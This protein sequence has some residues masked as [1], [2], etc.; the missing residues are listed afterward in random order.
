MGEVRLN[1]QYF[2]YEPNKFAG[3][4][5]T[6]ASALLDDFMVT[7]EMVAE[8]MDAEIIWSNTIVRGHV[9]VWAAPTNGGKTMLAMYAA[10]EL[11][12]AG[13]NVA[14]FQEDARRFRYEATCRCSKVRWLKAAEFYPW[15]KVC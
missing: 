2:D 4:P 8:M 9:Q 7:D 14:Y 11:A 5:V 15:R 12:N 1:A 3:D 10:K 13:F 6:S